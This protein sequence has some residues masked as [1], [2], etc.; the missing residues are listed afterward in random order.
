MSSP[1]TW[2]GQWSHLG[3]SGPIPLDSTELVLVIN[4][5]VV[6]SKPD[7]NLDSVFKSAW[8]QLKKIPFHVQA[9]LIETLSSTMVFAS[10]LGVESLSSLTV[11]N[12]P[13]KITRATFADLYCLI[14]QC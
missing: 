7:E 6:S 11:E 13:L 3:P 5:L 2:L 8:S 9:S 1:S 10:N 4:L 12:D 14:H